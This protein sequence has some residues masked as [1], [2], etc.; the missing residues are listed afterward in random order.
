MKGTIGKDTYMNRSSNIDA[1]EKAEDGIRS[2]HTTS[3]G[4][5]RR[6]NSPKWINGEMSHA[7]LGPRLKRWKA[8]E[9]SRAPQAVASSAAPKATSAKKGFFSRL[10]GR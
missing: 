1:L 5:A 8:I 6:F 9:R 2:Y 3:A 4:K 10:F 7:K